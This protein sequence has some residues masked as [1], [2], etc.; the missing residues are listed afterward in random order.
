MPW[1]LDVTVGQVRQ[2]RDDPN[3]CQCAG[4]QRVFIPTVRVLGLI[5]DYLEGRITEKQMERSLKRSGW[6]RGEKIC[7]H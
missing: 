1:E 7:A 5:E 2:Y 6:V 4:C 3:P